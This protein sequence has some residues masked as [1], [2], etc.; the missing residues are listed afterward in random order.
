M[1][2]L[3][4]EP[5]LQKRQDHTVAVVRVGAV[6]H[7]P[8]RDLSVEA[9]ALSQAWLVLIMT[10]LQTCEKLDKEDPWKLNSGGD[11]GCACT[12]LTPTPSL[13][14]VLAIASVCFIHKS[15]VFN[16]NSSMFNI[17]IIIS[18]TTHQIA[19]GRSCCSS[20]TAPQPRRDPRLA[21]RPCSAGPAP[22]R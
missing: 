19:P 21:S 15:S 2:L 16:R 9:Q 10:G 12:W 20:Y 3:A 4:S 18:Q 8:H 13:F 5:G 22:N 11:C 1:A 17:K 7:P 6:T 14:S